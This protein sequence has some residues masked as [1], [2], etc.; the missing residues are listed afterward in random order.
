VARIEIDQPLGDSISFDASKCGQAVD[1]LG[2]CVGAE[3]REVKGQ[4]EDR[5][6]G[7]GNR[8]KVN[9]AVVSVDARQVRGQAIVE[10]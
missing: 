2:C 3:E 10:T 7:A 6:R 4:L 5:A 1:R 8:L 9:R